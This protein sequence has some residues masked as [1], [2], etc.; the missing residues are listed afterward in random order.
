MNIE[1]IKESIKIEPYF[2]TDLGVLYN[3][4]C[5]DI[6]KHMPDKCVDLVL[7]DPP[8]NIG[9]ENKRTK[10]GN[11]IISNK[12]AWGEWDNFDNKDFDKFMFDCLDKWFLLLK[13]GGSL[14]CFTAREK[15]GFYCDYACHNIGFKYQNTMEI[16]KKNPLPHFTKTNWRS[17]FELAFY[18]SKN[19]PKTF[20]FMD[21]YVMKN[22]Y[23]YVIGNKESEHPTEKPIEAISLYIQVSSNK[24]DIVFDGFLGSG[25][26]AVACEQLNRQWI[27]VEISEK[28]CEIAKKRIDAETRQGKFKF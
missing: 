26:T 22:V 5:L 19:K 2:E 10:V 16:Y 21:Q 15:N 14:Y 28:Y 13:E 18:I 4:D 6:M 3:A 20:N 7:I 12:E 1:Q 25:T 23:D 27:G 8:Y 17:C 24:N 11:K 9:Q